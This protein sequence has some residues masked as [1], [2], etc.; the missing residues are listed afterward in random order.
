M[1]TPNATAPQSPLDGLAGAQFFQKWH[2]KRI[3]MKEKAA[4]RLND[5]FHALERPAV[6]PHSRH[7]SQFRPIVLELPP[8]YPNRPASSLGQHS[9]LISA[10]K[11]RDE[12]A[13]LLT[14]APSP[15][16]ERG[17]IKSKFDELLN[18]YF[19]TL[20]SRRP[21][22]PVRHKPDVKGLLA[23]IMSGATTA[24]ARESP[25][26]LPTKLSKSPIVKFKE[27]YDS[28]NRRG[29]AQTA[30]TMLAQKLPQRQSRAAPSLLTARPS[31]MHFENAVTTKK[32]QRAPRE[33]LRRVQAHLDSLNAEEFA[34]LPTIYKEGLK[35][36]AQT[37]ISR[38]RAQHG[39]AASTLAHY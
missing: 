27:E 26:S 8:R 37:V 3:E 39:R 34:A 14:A 36:L 38:L 32:Q 35:Q 23:G 19:A 17:G 28:M 9:Q 11:P 12:E 6:T 29:T 18:T 20:P 22:S 24:T 7:Q 10:A 31:A 2:Q 30:G 21:A 5:S 16:A 1:L 4:E 25:S 15:T 33:E 13:T